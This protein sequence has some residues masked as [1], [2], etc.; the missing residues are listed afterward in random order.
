MVAY[1]NSIQQI[2]IEHLPRRAN[3]IESVHQFHAVP[4]VLDKHCQALERYLRLYHLGKYEVG[5]IFFE[6]LVSVIVTN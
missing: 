4:I 6:P 2:L 5:E 3:E 1:Y